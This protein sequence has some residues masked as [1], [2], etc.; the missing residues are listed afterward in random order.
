[1][2]ASADVGAAILAGDAVF[3]E[4]EMYV[5]PRVRPTDEQIFEWDRRHRL[6]IDGLVGPYCFDSGTVYRINE[7][8]MD[9]CHCS[10]PVSDGDWMTP[11]TLTLLFVTFFGAASDQAIFPPM[12]LR[13]WRS[14]LVPPRSQTPQLSLLRRPVS[15]CRILPYS[16]AVTMTFEG[17]S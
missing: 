4:C 7:R 12:R 9:V 8:F 16:L 11:P 1:M 13:A 15:I 3:L 10:Y 5:A 2:N 6:P 14:V 17:A